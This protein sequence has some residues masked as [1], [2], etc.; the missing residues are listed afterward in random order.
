MGLGFNAGVQHLRVRGLG[1]SRR[2]GCILCFVC[3]CAFCFFR[4]RFFNSGCSLGVWKPGALESAEGM[5]ARDDIFTGL[6]EN[7]KPYLVAHR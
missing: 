6:P 7:P 2:S 4:L 5:A 3:V 1:Y